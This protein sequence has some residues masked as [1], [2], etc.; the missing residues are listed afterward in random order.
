MSIRN[1]FDN[2][3]LLADAPNSVE[4][5]RNL[6]LQLAVQGKLLQQNPQDEPASVLLARVEAERLLLFKKKTFKKIRENEDLLPTSSNGHLPSGWQIEWLGNLAH[7]I[8]K[9]ATPTTYGYSFQLEGIRFIKVENVKN[10]R[11]V[12][13]RINDFISKEAHNS[14]LRS[15]LEAGD[16]LFSIAGT[17]GETCIVRE[18][19]LPANINQALAIIRGT[20]TAFL[21]EFLKLQLDSF[22]ANAV[23]SR[24]RGGAMNNVSLRDLKELLVYVPPLEEQKRIV[25]KVDEL[26]RFCDELKTK[27][28]AKS[29]SRVRLN[30]AALAPLNKA[31]SLG[32]EDFE[33]ATSRLD[34]HF[35]TL[36]A[37]V[38]SIGKLRSTIL[39]LAINRRLVHIDEDKAETG[40]RVSDY[41]R[42]LNGYAFKSEWFVS[43]GIRLLRNTNV[44]HGT[45]QWNEVASIAKER[46]KEFAKFALEQGDIVISLD[47][48][49]I[50]TGLKVARIS[51]KDLPTLLLQR[52]GKVELK[53]C[54]IDSDY[55]FIWLQSPAFVNVINP[56]RSNGVPHISAKSIESIPFSPPHLNEQKRIV[57]KVNQLMAL[58]DDLEFKLRQ[59]EAH[60][61]K[62]MNAAVQHVLQSISSAAQVNGSFQLS[63]W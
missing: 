39:Q 33:Q 53:S 54:Q 2:F 42:I 41:V 10:N 27:Q 46:A 12:K 37:S 50:S 45:I 22:V 61:E 40:S 36:F 5:L 4:K 34:K 11:I 14:Q 9:G 6:I 28:Q 7:A 38:E 35:E 24:A 57:S 23:K 63:T 18:E 51:Q 1:V 19:D 15:Q 3:A 20:K 17:I 44:G 56:G 31:A 48:P 62:V 25:T 43:S 13:E 47:R 8:T 21:P 49:L 32:P 55:F 26:M 60:S 16:V 29:E 59:A 52:V 58:C 30:K